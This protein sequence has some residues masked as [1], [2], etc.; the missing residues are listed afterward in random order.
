MTIAFANS[1]TLLKCD[2]I[3]TATGYQYVGTYCV[4]YECK[5]VVIKIFNEYCPYLMPNN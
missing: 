4:D 2:G 5:F 3:S 1:G